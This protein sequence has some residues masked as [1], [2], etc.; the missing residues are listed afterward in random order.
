MDCL[1]KVYFFSRVPRTP[2]LVIPLLESEI[3]VET[4]IDEASGVNECASVDPKP[5]PAP[6]PRRARIY[7][8]K[9]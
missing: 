7:I 8:Y 6:S 4:D 3:I 9:Q 5:V 2:Q 1:A